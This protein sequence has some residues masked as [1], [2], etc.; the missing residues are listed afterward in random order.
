MDVRVPTNGRVAL[1]AHCLLN[2]NTKPYMRARFPGAVWEL[3][4]IL[5]EKDF[6]L[7]Q[8]PCPEVAF[9]GLNRFSQVKE[10]YDT[11][12]YREHCRELAAMV[13]DQL[14]QYPSYEYKTVLIGLDGSPSCGLRLTGTSKNWRGYPSN[15]EDEGYPVQKGRGILMEE[16]LAGHERRGLPAPPFFGVGLD[17]HGIDL[18]GITAAFRKELEETIRKR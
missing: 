3:L 17:V 13:C 9:A 10:Q 6:S 14:A 12:K 18:D 5:R 16:I 7:F 4:D 8:L 15:I 2:Q 1:L 11:P